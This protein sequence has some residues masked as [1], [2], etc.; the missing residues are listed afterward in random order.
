MTQTF[1]LVKARTELAQDMGVDLAGEDF[2]SSDHSRRVKEDCDDVEATAA[3]LRTVIRQILA[4]T[5][6]HYDK[7]VGF[8]GK[9]GAAA[10]PTVGMWLLEKRSTGH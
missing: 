8:L 5:Y 3:F 9:G 2:G 6:R 1:L 10:R 7:D 4:G